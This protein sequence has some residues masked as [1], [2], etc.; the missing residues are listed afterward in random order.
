VIAGKI[1]TPVLAAVARADG[2]DHGAPG[3]ARDDLRI[4]LDQPDHPA[5]D[6]AQSGKRDAQGFAHGIPIV[7]FRLAP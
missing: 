2:G 3:A 6:S 4:G 1:D 5:A 7:R